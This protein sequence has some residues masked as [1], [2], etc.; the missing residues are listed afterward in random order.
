MVKKQFNKPSSIPENLHVIS[1]WRFNVLSDKTQQRQSSLPEISNTPQCLLSYINYSYIL[2]ASASLT[3]VCCSS[4]CLL[5]WTTLSSLFKSTK[6]MEWEYFCHKM[7][8]ASSSWTAKR[9]IFNYWG[10][11]QLGELNPLNH[12]KT[13][14]HFKWH[15]VWVNR[16]RNLVSLASKNTNFQKYWPF[17]WKVCRLL[18]H[19]F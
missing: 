7:F 15:R 12:S 14:M 6:A 19:I 18:I 10:N 5:D 4:V 8:A 11:I 13:N 17:M 2:T 9:W 3:N 1:K 16:V